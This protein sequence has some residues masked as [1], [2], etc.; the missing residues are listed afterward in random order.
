[1]QG[2]PTRYHLLS[3]ISSA[4]TYVTVYASSLYIEL[5]YEQ[6]IASKIL[7]DFAKSFQHTEVL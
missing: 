2:M 6:N 5:C 4:P 3:F 1:M 7:D